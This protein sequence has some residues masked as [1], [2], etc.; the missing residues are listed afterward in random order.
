MAGDWIKNLFNS[1]WKCPENIP[2]F[3]SLSFLPS[4]LFEVLD[5]DRLIQVGFVLEFDLWLLVGLVDSTVVTNV[6]HLAC[7]FNCLGNW[8][9]G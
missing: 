5:E 3:I 1:P 7:E 8:V 6:H 2:V 4:S 9:L